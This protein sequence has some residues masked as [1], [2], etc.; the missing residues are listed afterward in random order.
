MKE[1]DQRKILVL[2]G[3]TSCDG[4]TTMRVCLILRKQN[5]F[6]LDWIPMLQLEFGRDY[7]GIKVG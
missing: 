4:V 3:M 2:G 1:L 7:G 6:Y 5:T